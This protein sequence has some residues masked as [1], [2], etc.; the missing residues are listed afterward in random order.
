MPNFLLTFVRCAIGLALAELWLGVAVG[1][2]LCLA[3]GNFVVAYFSLAMQGFEPT[4]LREIAFLATLAQ[5]L[6]C[7][8]APVA[9]VFALF[10]TGTTNVVVM[11]ATKAA[12]Q[13]CQG[14]FD[15]REAQRATDSQV[16][17]QTAALLDRF[18]KAVTWL[19]LMLVPTVLVLAYDLSLFRAGYEGRVT[20]LVEP[21]E[22]L[23]WAPEA[24]TRVGHFLAPFIRTATWGYLGCILG[25]A[26]A[27]EYAFE[28]AA[29]RWQV[30]ENVILQVI[31]GESMREEQPTLQAPAEAVE[32]GEAAAPAHSAVSAERVAP[33][34]AGG[35]P[36]SAPSVPPGPAETVPPPEE[37]AAPPVTAPSAGGAEAEV[38]VIVGP[39]QIQRIPLAEVEAHPDRFVRDSSGRNL[40]LRTYYEQVM[41][42]A[43][44]EEGAR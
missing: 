14:I 35:A 7:G 2:M 1:I 20:N 30:L 10:I 12:M 5:A 34:I 43:T 11:T 8:E 33:P 37:P 9:A 18:G 13:V 42:Q 38:A 4:P 26:L 6:G 31:R 3:I 40:F 28:R 19:V 22:M 17:N 24:V 36:F 23:R 29:E 15:Y 44:Q 21:E 39:G 25:M 27:V 16:H 41:G 32:V